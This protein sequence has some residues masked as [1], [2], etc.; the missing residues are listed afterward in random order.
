MQIQET[1]LVVDDDARVLQA[2]GRALTLIGYAVLTAD[3]GEQGIEIYA[4]ERPDVVITDVRMP[5]VDG[6]AVLQR[7]REHNP[8][9]EVILITGHGDMEMAI[10]ALRA[11]A[12]DFVVKP[13]VAD[14][15]EIA[16]QRAQKR[17]RLRRK[18][19]TLQTTSR[20]HK[21]AVNHI[22]GEANSFKNL[23]AFV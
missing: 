13:V 16:L 14:Q 22:V 4:H 7:V 10:A 9:A 21:T 17:L 1:I 23:R 18:L 20:P 2:F 19:H 11:G 6:F 5:Q 15:L 12:S 3:S 8:D